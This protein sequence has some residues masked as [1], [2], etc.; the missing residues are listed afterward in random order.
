[1]AIEDF[2]GNP[3]ADPPTGKLGLTTSWEQASFATEIVAAFARANSHLNKRQVQ[4]I[5]AVSFTAGTANHKSK[6]VLKP[7]DS[8]RGEYFYL[9]GIS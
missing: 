2:I 1:M 3:R 4:D 7:L 6:N 8:K 9:L 5:I